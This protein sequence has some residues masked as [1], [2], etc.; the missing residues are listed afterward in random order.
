M[1]TMHDVA[2]RASVSVTTVSHVVNDTRPVSDELRHRVLSAMRDLDYKPNRVARGLRRGKTNT[3]GMIIADPVNPFF[4]EV[5]RGVAAAS[6][7]SDYS[8]ILC[9]AEE[10]P[11][12][13]FHY[14]NVLLEKQ[15]DGLILTTASMEAD[16]VAVLQE[17]Q[18]PLV[19]VDREIPGARADLIRT[20]HVSGAREA[21]EHLLRQGHRR[22]ACLTGPPNVMNALDRRA[23]Y[24]LALAQAGLAVDETLILFGDWQFA[25]GYQHMRRLLA[26][27]DPPTAVFACN[28]LMAIGALRVIAESGRRAPDDIALVGFDDIP[29]ASY[30]TP[31][32]TT[33]RQPMYDLGWQAAEMLF[34]RVRHSEKRLET[35]LL[36]AKLVVRQSSVLRT[37][38]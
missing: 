12:K 21:T 1:I 2:K 30:V 27:Q 35:R 5:F 18:V 25:S 38:G 8:V 32:L 36:D 26:L 31:T 3:I 17:R 24:E 28:D 29:L 9:N 19:V 7:A 33:M 6:D 23:G 13:E 22:I 16:H 14:T 11:E 37:T 15:V 20:D 4:A 10:D 34:D